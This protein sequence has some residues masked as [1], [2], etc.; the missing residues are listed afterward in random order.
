M[1]AEKVV[2]YFRT[3][4]LS[5]NSLQKFGRRAVSGMISKAWYLPNVTDATR[6]HLYAQNIFMT[7]HG[8]INWEWM[9]V[10]YREIIWNGWTSFW[11][12]SSGGFSWSRQW[13]LASLSITSR[14]DEKP[15][16][17]KVAQR[18]QKKSIYIYI[19]F[20]RLYP[21]RLIILKNFPCT[22]EFNEKEF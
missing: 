16:Q 14:F 9:S 21:M 13:K 4:A 19:Y 3:R 1:R 20:Y 10:K 18:Y 2:A 6:L 15:K 12:G 5:L 11:I 17:P 8:R 22:L 7:V